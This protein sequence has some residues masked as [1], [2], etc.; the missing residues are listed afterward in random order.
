MK[1]FTITCNKCGRSRVLQ[2]NWDIDGEIK[3]TAVNYGVYEDDNRVEIQ[4]KCDYA[5]RE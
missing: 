3:I 5:I 4:C 2:H 1:G